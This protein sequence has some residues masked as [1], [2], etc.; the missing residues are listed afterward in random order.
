MSNPTQPDVLRMIARLEEAN[1]RCY[2]GPPRAEEPSSESDHDDR[3]QSLSPPVAV[4]PRSSRARV[5]LIAVT[6]LLFATSPYLTTF[7]WKTAYLETVKS[8][9][10]RWANAS[11]LRTVSQMPR[12]GASQALLAPPEVERQVRMMSSALEDLEQQIGQLKAS[13]DQ[14]IRSGAEA[15]ARLKGDREQLMRD[16]TNIAEQLKITQEQLKATQI[17]LAEVVSSETANAG[18]KSSRRK[19]VSGFLSS[20]GARARHPVR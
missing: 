19:H 17:Q 14:A 8:T 16:N 15:E 13:Q 11:E 12:D 6:A 4:T 1:A 18:R 10:A 3:H 9:I 2:K 7:G 5:W 20:Q